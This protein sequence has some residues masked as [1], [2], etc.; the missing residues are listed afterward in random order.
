M[1]RVKSFLLAA[2]A[3]FTLAAPALAQTIPISALPTRPSALGGSEWF[4]LVQGSHTYKAAVSDIASGLNLGSAASHN[5]GTAGN[6][7]PLLLNGNTWSGTQTFSVAPVF[8][9][10]PGSRSALGITYSLSTANAWSARQTFSGGETLT[11]VTV[12]GLGSASSAGTGA[13]GQVSDAV[14][15]AQGQ[16]VTGGGSLACPVWSNGAAWLAYGAAVPIDVYFFQG[17]VAGNSY[18]LGAYQPSTNLILTS[19]KAACAYGTA[20]TASTAYTLT[21]NG[22]TV[23]TVTFTS[24]GCSVSFGSSPYTVTAGH[25]LKLNGPATADTT[26]AD[27]GMTFGGARD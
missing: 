25:T 26:L 19:G 13:R 6:S 15:C 17:G 20:A 24:S 27:A 10:Q 8:S 9:D 14:T 2:L 12:S 16:A 4:P 11:P 7:V 23:A 5:I 18:T 22:S 3:V 1:M 21:D